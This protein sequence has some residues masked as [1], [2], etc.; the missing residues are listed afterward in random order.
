MRTITLI[1][2]FG[3]RDEYVGVLKGVILS[4]NPG[5]T[6]VDISHHIPPQQV[7]AAGDMLAAAFPW[8]PEGSIH[9]AVVDPGVGSDREIVAV[10]LKAH[11]F[12]APNN[13]ILSAVLEAGP[14]ERIVRVENEQLYRRPV[15]NTFHGR[16]IFAPVAA[17]LSMGMSLDRLGPALSMAQVL[18]RIPEQP[19]TTSQ[20]EIVGQVRYVDR[21]GNLGSNIELETMAPLLER[22]RNKEGRVEVRI[23]R[24]TIRGVSATYAQNESGALMALFNSRQRLEIAV[25]RGSAA[26]VTNARLGD[27]IRVR[28]QKLIQDHR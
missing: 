15:S 5:A 7:D 23:G 6:I 13:G 14:V 25:N 17:H 10:A 11:T 24:H 26:R 2:D 9:L 16:D 19:A 22:S 28:I 1:T 20:G 18:R 27:P 4:I 3:T 21:F 12:L 8:F